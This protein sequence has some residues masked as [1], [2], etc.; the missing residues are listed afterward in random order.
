MVIGMFSESYLPMINGV[1]T[2]IHTLRKGLESLGH[3][4]YVIC[5]DAE[6]KE[7]IKDDHVIRLK[8][9]TIPLKSLNNFKLVPNAY[10]KFKKLNLNIKFD[11]IHIHTEFPMG[12][13]G[14][15]ISKMEHIP[16][17]YTFHTMYED[18]GHYVLPFGFRHI[19]MP[20]YKIYVK[21]KFNRVAKNA[22]SLIIPTKKVED[23][24]KRFKV[25]K[26]YSII[27]TGIDLS[28]FDKNIYDI[29]KIKRI[30]E[31]FNLDKITLLYIGRISK[32]KSIDDLIKYFYDNKFKDKYKLFIVGNG[33]YLD[34][35]KNLV[36]K[37][38]LT[39]SVIF[40]GPVPND[41]VGLYYQVGDVFVNASHSETQGLTIVEAM[42]SGLPILTRYD[43]NLDNVIIHKTNG[44]FYNNEEEFFSN[45][46]EIILNKELNEALRNNACISSKEYNKEA[47]TKNV[48]DVYNKYV[49]K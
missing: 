2:S 34:T 47:F 18:Y 3:T 41:E 42:S 12:R 24:L 14:I 49:T 5:T 21:N 16:L 44:M 26:P 9:F 39:D 48:L 22:S 36:K 25:N 13:L 40:A 43:V 10:K 37:D 29:E 1:V 20:F 4:V 32:E 46:N 11:L 38:N 17:I 7:E 15:K 31:K 45:L 8:G 6:V 23:M 28:K 35:L 19:G 27:P 33:P 30:K